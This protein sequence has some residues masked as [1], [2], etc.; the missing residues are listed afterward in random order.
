MEKTKRAT[1]K[2][3]CQYFVWS[4]GPLQKQKQRSCRGRGMPIFHLV[5]QSVTEAK[6]KGA[7]GKGMLIVC[8][9]G[10]SPKTKTKAAPEKR[11][12]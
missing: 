1:E 9:F 11:G 2:R 10:Q 6:T 12:C 8:L 4:V 3:E 5:G 7:G